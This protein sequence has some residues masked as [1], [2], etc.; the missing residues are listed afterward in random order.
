MHGTVTGPTDDARRRELEAVHDAYDMTRHYAH[1]SAQ[2]AAV[3]DR[4][5]DDFGVAGPVGYCVERLQTLVE[6]GVTR[7]VV[8]AGVAGGDPAEMQAARRLLVDEVLPAV[9]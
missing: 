9:R 7:I 6:L 2:A 4:V 1:G 5:I 3:S 8:Q